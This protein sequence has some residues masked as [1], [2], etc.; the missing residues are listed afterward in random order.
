MCLKGEKADVLEFNFTHKKYKAKVVYEKD[1]YYERV[2]VKIND[3]FFWIGV[4]DK[5]SGKKTY[6]KRK[7]LA[8]DIVFALNLL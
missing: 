5:C 4:M 1:S 7:E 3:E 2:G 6:P 8:K